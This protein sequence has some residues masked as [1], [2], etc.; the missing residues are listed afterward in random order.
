[1]QPESPIIEAARQSHR[2]APRPCGAPAVTA[3]IGFWHQMPPSSGDSARGHIASDRAALAAAYV[4]IGAAILRFQGLLGIPE[5]RRR[6]FVDS[7]SSDL[8]DHF[9][10]IEFEF[11]GLIG[12]AIFSRNHESVTASFMIDLSKAPGDELYV[13]PG[14]WAVEAAG[15]L[16]QAF[17]D[18]PRLLSPNGDRTLLRE[19]TDYLYE[20]F[21]TTF[22]QRLEIDQ[23]IAKAGKVWEKFVDVRGL[24]LNIGDEANFQRLTGPDPLPYDFLNV[25]PGFD[26]DEAAEAL[27]R[28]WP[29]VRASHAEAS[30]VEFVMNKLIRGRAIF[31][32]AFGD[33]GVGIARRRSPPPRVGSGVVRFLVMTNG[34]GA[35]RIRPGS[36]VET[37][38]NRWQI[39][40]LI[41]RLHELAGMRMM[42]LRDLRLIKRAGQDLRG[43]GARLDEIFRLQTQG[44]G[45]VSRDD[46]NELFQSLNSLGSDTAGGLSYR[47]NRARLMAQSYKQTLTDLEVERIEGCQTYDEFMR[48]RV[49]HEFDAIDRIGIRVERLSNR[50]TN[51]L[52]LVDTTN[53]LENGR[54]IAD[55]TSQVAE[56][57]AMMAKSQ[58]SMLASQDSIAASERKIAHLQGTAEL[59]VA[60]G[61]I[62]YF[63]SI[64]AKVAAFELVPWLQPAVRDGIGRLT[65]ISGPHIVD[66]LLRPVEHGVTV[67]DE[68][69][70]Y[71]AAGIVVGLFVFVF[72]RGQARRLEQRLKRAQSARPKL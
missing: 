58:H 38:F 49:F 19:H 54:K 31:V 22:M 65:C 1:M 72:R 13:L 7:H 18:M 32:S 52:S 4:E 41:Y 48:R 24:V 11:G 37:P 53:E 25:V 47:I 2:R 63:G 12:K 6:S 45:L 67:F 10:P 50:A 60:T 68:I 3:H 44:D 43:L 21:W 29:L 42:A 39:G 36:K 51:L 33:P 34:L 35:T 69:V 62:Y 26:A 14:A 27:H 9:I 66:V 15:R 57:Q 64:L 5:A 30:D 59:L 23:T 55:M 46:I 28:A 61:A 20:Q 16:K 70:C 71:L 40:R 8:P 17:E 56:S